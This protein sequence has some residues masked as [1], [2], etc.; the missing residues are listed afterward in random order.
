MVRIY[1]LAVALVVGLALG[2]LFGGASESPEPSQADAPVPLAQTPSTRPSGRASDPPAAQAVPPAPSATPAAPASPEVALAF[3]AVGEELVNGKRVSRVETTET[4]HADFLREDRDDSW[5][6]MREAELES[7]M[8]EEISTG[9][10]RKE[11]IECRATL[12]EIHLTAKGDEQTA[13]L[14]KWFEDRN[15]LLRDPRPNSHLQPQ[16]QMRMSSYTN[17]NE[18]GLAEVKFTYQKLVQFMAAPARN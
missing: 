6:Y 11:R 17:Q 15:E 9:R 7:D 16:M 4:L 2:L 1:W 18:Q 14:K 3:E 12:C 13:A 5:A 8:L 10:F